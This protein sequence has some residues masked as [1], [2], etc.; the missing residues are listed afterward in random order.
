MPQTVSP[1]RL[2]QANALQGLSRNFVRILGPAI[3]GA[4]VVAGSPGTALAIDAVSFLVC[5]VL[6]ARIRV[7]RRVRGDD[8]PSFLRE[9]REGWTEFVS[10]TWL[11]STVIVFGLGT[12]SSAS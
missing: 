8:A 9:L 12:S 7:P 2:Q 10:R 3:G 5:A 6:L 11:W 4:I 1:A